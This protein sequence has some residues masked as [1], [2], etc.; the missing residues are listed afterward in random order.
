M[1]KITAILVAFLFAL[2][3]S[4]CTESNVITI[5]E[6]QWDSAYFHDQVVKIIIE[7]GYGVEVDIIPADTNIMVTSLK[8]QDINLTMELWSDNVAT[9]D[10]DIANGEY[11]FVSTNFDDNAQGL[12][13]PAYMQVQ[14]PE[15]DT[16]Q[17]LLDPAYASLFSD[18]EDPS[19]GVIYGGTEGWSATVFLNNKM[20]EYGLDEFY[21]FNAINSTAALNASLASA[22]EQEEPWVGYNWEPTWVLGVYDMVLLEDSPY[23]A[24]DFDLGIGAFPAVDVNICVD[25]EFESNYPEVFGFLQNYVTSSAITNSA[26]AYMNENDV[27]AYEAA[28]WFLQ[29]NTN[30]WQ[31]WVTDDAADSIMEAIQ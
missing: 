22:Y 1:K 15:L 12:Y 29:N 16:V 17:D 10:E 5:G 23:N 8:T 7:E 31:A 4:A 24:D 21:N 20:T 9:Y 27:G 3:L 6:G 11:I 2:G 25:T 14:Y 28:V 19:K 26:L 30:I 13:I 18:P